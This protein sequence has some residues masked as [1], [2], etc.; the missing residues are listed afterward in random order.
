LNPKSGWWEKGKGKN[1]ET[2]VREM[3][4]DMER[5]IFVRNERREYY[6]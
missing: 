2:E 4:K 1:Q 5:G 6:E 3:K